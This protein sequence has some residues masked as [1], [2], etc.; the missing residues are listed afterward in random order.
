MNNKQK[1]FVTLGTI[2]AFITIAVS[3]ILYW[4]YQEQTIIKVMFVILLIL[5]VTTING[6]FNKKE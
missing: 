4:I 2:S 5:A 1:A 3:G 6:F